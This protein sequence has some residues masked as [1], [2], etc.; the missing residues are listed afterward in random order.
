MPDPADLARALHVDLT[1]RL[2]LTQACLPLLAK[3]GAGA[4]VFVLDDPAR[5]GGALRIMSLVMPVNCVM[6]GGMGR[7]GLMRL[8]HSASTR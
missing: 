6:V 1:A 2:W 5:S 8:F 7:L 3:S 4:A